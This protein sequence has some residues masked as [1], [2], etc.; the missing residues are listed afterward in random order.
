MAG[1]LKVGRILPLVVGLACC[2]FCYCTLSSRQD[3]RRVLVLVLDTGMV[4]VW[5]VPAEPAR[6][7]NV[8]RGKLSDV[9]RDVPTLRLN[10]GVFV[11]HAVLL[12]MWGLMII[13]FASKGAIRDFQ[14]GELKV[15]FVVGV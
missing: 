9:L 7:V 6:H 13:F 14:P 8:V 5:L 2:A 1:E 12:A 10:F 11:L 4:V 15:L 3:T